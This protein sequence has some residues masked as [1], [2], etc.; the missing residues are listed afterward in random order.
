MS[1]NKPEEDKKRREVVVLVAIALIGLSVFA[2]YDK[3]FSS[4]ARLIGK[5]RMVWYEA[6][7]EKDKEVAIDKAV[8]AALEEAAKPQ[9][10]ED[11]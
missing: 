2:I 4:Q 8:K 3:V 10:E 9:D 6:K 5:W 1:N 7:A 11:S